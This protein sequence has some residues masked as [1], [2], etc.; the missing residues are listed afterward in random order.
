MA[1][2]YRTKQQSSSCLIVRSQLVWTNVWSPPSLILTR[3]TADE[4]LAQCREFLAMFAVRRE[5]CAIGQLVLRGTRIVVPQNLRE[6]V[7]KLAHE[8]HTGIVAMKQ[9]LRSKVWWPGIDRQAEKV[10][11][12][13]FRCQ[14]TSNPTKPEPMARI[15]LPNAPWEHLACDL[16]GPLPSGD[17]IFVACGLH[18]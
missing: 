18:C 13:C 11:R 1:Q 4:I 7:L 14:L 3:S 16:L 5:P 8:G 15:E 17:Y 12:E 9:R 2:K 10:C 6:Q